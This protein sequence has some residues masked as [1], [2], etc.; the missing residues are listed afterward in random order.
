MKA[1]KILAVQTVLFIRLRYRSY[2]LSA[3]RHSA[4]IFFCFSVNLGRFAGLLQVKTKFFLGCPAFVQYS[5]RGCE[6]RLERRKV[7]SKGII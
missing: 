5:I 3:F 2:A 1:L 7:L 6:C 4:R